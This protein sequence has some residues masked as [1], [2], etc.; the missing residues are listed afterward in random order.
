MASLQ[1]RIEMSAD[2]ELPT[3]YV[4][5]DVFQS[6]NKAPPELRKRLRNLEIP[7]GGNPNEWETVPLP[8]GNYEVQVSLPSGQIIAKD[9]HV[10]PGENPTR[11]VMHTNSPHES[12]SIQ[13][14]QGNISRYRLYQPESESP[15]QNCVKSIL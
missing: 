6:D 13:H 2:H 10:D 11:V 7:A 9:V 3:A 4:M 1:I 12:L 8:P 14:F 5:C 15:K